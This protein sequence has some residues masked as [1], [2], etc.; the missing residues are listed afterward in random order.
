[1]NETRIHQI[2]Q[3]SILFKGTH[4]L[5]E[6]IGGL[7]L[8]FINTARIRSLVDTFTQTRLVNDPDDYIATHLMKMA[9]GFS[10]SSQHFY[11]FYLLSHRL[12]KALLVIALLKN[13]LWAYPLS[14]FVLGLFIAY[15]LY[16][17]SYTQ[18]SV[19]LVLTVFDLFIMVLIWHEYGLVRQRKTLS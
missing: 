17:Y 8:V 9:E 6:C 15:Q 2:F 19:L 13:K 12:I 3:I 5:I 10:V 11:A 1:M 18:S 14:L 7:L 16:R 4:A